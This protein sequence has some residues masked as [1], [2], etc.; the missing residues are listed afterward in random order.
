M[1]MRMPVMDGYE[2]TRRIKASAKGQAT[3]VIALTASA[4]EADRTAILAVGCDDFV[5]KP[6]QEAEIFDGMAEHLGVRYIY[7][8]LALSDE[9]DSDSQV[10][11]VLTPADLAV[12][13]P[14]WI[15]DLRQ[16]AMQGESERLLELVGQIESE[17]AAL[18][19]AVA[20]LVREFRFD[21]IMVLTDH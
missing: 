14:G 12:L 10:Q 18:A 6:F 9:R 8:E 16:A 5:R 11:V 13:P 17:Y 1:D 3:V 4:F 20:Q 7:E 15:A 2:A 19:R 21:R